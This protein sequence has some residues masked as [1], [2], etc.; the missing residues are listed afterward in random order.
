MI[1][2]DFGWIKLFFILFGFIAVCCSWIIIYLS[3]IVMRRNEN[4][5]TDRFYI[6][7]IVIGI[8]WTIFILNLVNDYAKALEGKVYLEYN[9]VIAIDSEREF[10]I[11][12]VSKNELIEVFLEG[13]EWK[14]IED[15]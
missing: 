7:R 6:L 9:G 11:D 13:S 10:F 12:M 3:M 14:D 2:F 4:K 1:I 8:G 5:Y 15:K